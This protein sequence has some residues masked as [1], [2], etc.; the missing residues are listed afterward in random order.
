MKTKTKIYAIAFMSKEH[1]NNKTIDYANDFLNKTKNIFVEKQTNYAIKVLEQTKTQENRAILIC[2]ICYNTK[3]IETNKVMIYNNN[4]MKEIEPI[5]KELEENCH[6]LLL[7]ENELTPKFT[8]I[9]KKTYYDKYK[10][11]II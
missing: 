1:K 8:S 2:V 6:Y 9:A 7:E 3:E 10:E 4:L 5:L 11:E